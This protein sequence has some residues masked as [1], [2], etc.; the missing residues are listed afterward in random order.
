MDVNQVGWTAYGHN[1]AKLGRLDS[2]GCIRHQGA[3]VFRIVGDAI[4][5]M[6]ERYLGRLQR[7]IGSTERGE[8]LFVL[9]G[10]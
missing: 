4:Y 9:C 3:V 7:G 10:G 5:S 1:R 2:D 8:L 6:H